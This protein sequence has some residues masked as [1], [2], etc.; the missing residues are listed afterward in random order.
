MFRN[1]N[2]FD[3]PLS[4]KPERFALKET[5]SKIIGFGLGK[6]KL[7]LGIIV[8]VLLTIK[9]TD[10]CRTSNH[11]IRAHNFCLHFAGKRSCVGELI[12]RKILFLF[13]TYF[14]QKYSISL[15][16]GYE[17]PSTEPL[18]GFTNSPKPFQLTITERRSV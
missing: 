8:Y 18:L 16:K 3:D 7:N 17:N 15:P 11:T 14:F 1:A 10:L 12:V 5:K 6:D 2:D 4:F 9:K 13:T